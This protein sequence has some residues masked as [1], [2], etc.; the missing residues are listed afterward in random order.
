MLVL[1]EKLHST[2]QISHVLQHMEQFPYYYYNGSVLSQF[3]LTIHSE[4]SSAPR[5]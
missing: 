4:E 1:L 2:C 3:L 5:N